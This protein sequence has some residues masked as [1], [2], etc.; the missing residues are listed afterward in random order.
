MGDGTD[1]P[2][3]AGDMW[4]IDGTSIKKTHATTGPF[5]SNHF[6]VML[7]EALSGTG[8]IGWYSKKSGLIP[9]FLSACDKFGEARGFNFEILRC[10][11]AGENKSFVTQM[12]GKD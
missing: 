1:K 6:A 12:N 2:K 7:I 9:D 11:G 10:D 5:P 4:Y 3:K 8:I